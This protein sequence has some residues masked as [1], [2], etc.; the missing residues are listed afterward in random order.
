MVPSMSSHDFFSLSITAITTL[1]ALFSGF[2]PYEIQYF[3][4]FWLLSSLGPISVVFV[5]TKFVC[6]RFLHWNHRLTVGSCRKV[7]AFYHDVTWAVFGHALI[8]WVTVSSFCEYILLFKSLTCCCSLAFLYV[9]VGRSCCR[10]LVFTLYTMSGMFLHFCSSLHT[11][12]AI[13]LSSLCA[14]V[15]APSHFCSVVSFMRMLLFAWVRKSEVRFG[16]ACWTSMVFWS[17]VVSTVFV[18]SSV[19]AIPR[20]LA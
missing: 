7:S 12:V 1:F 19:V 17:S 20:S 4:L 2:F 13:S 9:L 8:R 11:S 10:R 16:L 14:V 15:N 3:N 6:G 5:D 18:L